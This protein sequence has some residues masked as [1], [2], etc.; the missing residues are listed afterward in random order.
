MWVT[1]IFFIFYFFCR[2]L[3]W[4]IVLII[5]TCMLEIRCH[6]TMSLWSKET[7][8]QPQG[9]PKVL[10]PTLN[11]NLTLFV[12]PCKRRVG[13][14]RFTRLQFMSIFSRFPSNFQSSM[15]IFDCKG[16]RMQD[17]PN[18]CFKTCYRAHSNFNHPE[19][20]LW[21]TKGDIEVTIVI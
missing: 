5:A 13:L 3:M 16:V 12:I 20:L 4:V 14:K 15:T 17:I 11:V 8:R 19:Q 1:L 21:V 9:R 7:L 6:E 18:F 10:N 2:K